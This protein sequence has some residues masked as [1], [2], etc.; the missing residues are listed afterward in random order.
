MAEYYEKIINEIIEEGLAGKKKKEYK[1]WR[2]KAGGTNRKSGEV[3]PAVFNAEL[4]I[5]APKKFIKSIS[6][7]ILIPISDDR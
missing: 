4:T 2:N 7:K 5:G 3:H 1:T 6:T